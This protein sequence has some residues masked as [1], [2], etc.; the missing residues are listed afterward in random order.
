MTLAQLQR[1][2]LAWRRYSGLERQ[3]CTIAM[4]HRSF[5]LD[6]LPFAAMLLLSRYPGLLLLV[7]GGALAIVRRLYS[8]ARQPKTAA[9]ARVWFG[10]PTL[11]LY[12]STFSMGALHLLATIVCII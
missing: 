12:P 9:A 8:R 6:V 4:R 5:A 10:S 7:P 1:G 3:W 2:A 11:V